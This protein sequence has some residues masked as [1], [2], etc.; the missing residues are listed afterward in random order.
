MVGYAIRRLLA[1]IPVLVMVTLV[2]FL[3]IKLVPGDPAAVIGGPEATDAQ[4]D[5]IRHQLG[6][7]Q[8]FLVQMGGWYWR[9][10]HG[11][12]GDSFLLSRPVSQAIVERLPVT[13]SL[14]GLSM[15]ISVVVAVALGLLSA[16]R[17]NT[18]RD[19]FA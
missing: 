5:Q 3:M 11:D 8:P 17:A 2:T 16:V 12:L 9:L 14:T 18:W 13:L 4:L 6:L 1:A 7:D 15:L 10:L 19:Q